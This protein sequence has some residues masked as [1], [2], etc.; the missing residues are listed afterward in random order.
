MLLTRRQ[1]AGALLAAPLLASRSYA[2]ETWPKM[3]DPQLWRIDVPP[4]HE[5]TA[6]GG[7]NGQVYY[8]I[9]GEEP[10]RTPIVALHGGPAGGHTYMRPYSALATDRQVV[11]YD[12]SGCG[13]SA[14]PA[15][16]SLYTIDRYVGELE[17][18]RSHLGLERMIVLGHSWGSVLAPAYAASYPDRVE[19][20]VLTGSVTRYRDYQEAALR[21]LRA[22]GPGVV[23]TVQAAEKSGNTADPAYQ[24]ILDEYYHAHVIRLKTWPQWVLDTFGDLDDNPVYKSLNGTSEFSLTGTLLNVDLRPKLARLHMPAL[25]SCGEFDEAPPW[26][27]RKVAA[28]LSNAQFH[29]FPGL[30][31]CPHIEDPERAMAVTRSFIQGVA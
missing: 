18:L 5:G 13:R 6:E 12:Q 27:G 22:M 8:R 19:A 4:R 11:L 2:A 15:D 24:K 30:G 14:R 10:G 26:V 16:L 7:P 3:P 23:A 31:H 29:A 21:W 28:A 9:Y 25:V 1:V 17:A 20:I